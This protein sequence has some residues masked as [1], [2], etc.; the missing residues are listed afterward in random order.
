MRDEVRDLSRSRALCVTL[1][2]LLVLASAAA[3]AAAP[4]AITV[5]DLGVEIAFPE[6]MTFNARVEAAAGI[7]RVT[8][9][10][11]VDKLTCGTVVAKAFPGFEPGTSAD[12]SWTWEM[13]QSGS[14]PPGATIWYRWR[15]VDRAGRETAS[16]EQRVT[17]LDDVHDWQSISQ[18][19]LTFHWY[20]APR[21]FAEDLLTSAAAS[22]DQLA[23]ATGLAPQ[24]PIDM[25]IYADTA[26]MRDAVLYEPGWTGGLAYPDQDIV[27]IG[28]SPNQ[29]DWGKRTEAHEPGP[30]RILICGSLYL[31]G[32]VL[33]DNS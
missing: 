21:A 33:K 26:D 5:D 12:V 23:Q 27:I 25:Y 31:A 20:G 14:E 6:R 28:I 10:Y 24:A 4:S 32:K 8:L 13:L 22:L 17:W 19:V 2:A 11:G 9:E 15:V 7:A 16:E 29:V 30:K 3:V 1:V 18:G